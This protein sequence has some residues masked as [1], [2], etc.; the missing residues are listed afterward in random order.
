MSTSR[1][2]ARPARTAGFRPPH[3]PNRDCPFYD[4]QP[5]WKFRRTGWYT[6]PS[7]GARFPSFQCA[8]CHRYFSSRTFAATYWLRYRNLFPRIAN[9]SVNGPGLRQI[10]RIFHIA[11]ATAARHLARAGRH[12]LLLHQHTIQTLRLDEPIVID[13]FETFEFSQY[14][15]LHFNLAVGGRSWFLYH[16]TDSPLRRKGSMTARQ[17]RTRLELETRLG[18]PDPK[19]VE[20]GTVAL[21]QPLLPHL[22]RG[23]TAETSI[24]HDRIQPDPIGL[25]TRE[26]RLHSDDHPAYHRALE[27]IRIENPTLTIRH[28]VTSSRARRT[29]SNPLFPVNLADLLLRHS[30]ANHRRETIAFSKR[31]QAA[32]ERLAV[33][34]VWRNLIKRRREKEAGITAAMT[35]QLATEPWTWRRVFRRRLFVRRPGLPDLWWEYYWRRVR[36]TILG[37]RQTT[38]NLQYA[39]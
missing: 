32:A 37:D 23:T 11:H 15:P 10:G 4:P 19:A 22:S 27:R 31:R 9:H 35:I 39:F 6:R 21:L 29:T 17:R 38:H 7:D 36:T 3:C 34:V 28:L 26:I 13:G 8:H 18:R 20:V 16:F 2:T 24:R 5:A 14:F 33:F 1:P 30:G 25:Q 12:C